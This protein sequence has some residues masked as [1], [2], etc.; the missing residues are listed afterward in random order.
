MTASLL[1]IEAFQFSPSVEYKVFDD[2]VFLQE[3]GEEL[4]WEQRFVYRS[5]MCLV[6]QEFAERS[7]GLNDESEFKCPDGNL[8]TL[9]VRFE[10]NECRAEYWESGQD[11]D[12]ISN[13][14]EYRLDT[15]FESFA[16]GVYCRLN[17]LR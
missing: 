11:E 5:F 4:T 12:G 13:A 3:D 2:G 8:G 10:E 7:E 14:K 1:N 17:G 15:D 16:N 6:G 9:I